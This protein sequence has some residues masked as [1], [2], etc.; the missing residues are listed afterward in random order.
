MAAKLD[1]VIWAPFIRRDKVLSFST[2]I[3]V[4]LG[5]P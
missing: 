5:K 2:I 3:L 1:L 4:G